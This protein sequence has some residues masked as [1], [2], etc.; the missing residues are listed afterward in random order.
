MA[1][2]F[3]KLSQISLGGIVHFKE[4]LLEIIALILL[5]TFLLYEKPRACISQYGPCTQLVNSKYK[6][7]QKNPKTES[8][9]LGWNRV[10][11]RALA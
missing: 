7:R 2:R 1:K 3:P 6:P 8:D 10:F 11:Q 9:L 4:L 5:A